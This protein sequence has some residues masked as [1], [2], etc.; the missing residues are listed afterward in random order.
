LKATALAAIT[1]I[2]G[3]PWVPGN[4]IDCSFFSISGLALG[5]DDAAARAAQGLVGGGGDHV[6]MRHRARIDARGDQ[7]GDMRHVDHKYA[8]TLSAIARQTR[9]VD[10]LRIG[11]EAADQHL[12]L[13]L[14]RQALDLVVVDQPVSCRC[15]TARR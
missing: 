14:D 10:H 13:V 1:C 9:P 8:P 5:Q 11:R 15:R 4:T 3:P 12:R 6:G 7:T 2:S